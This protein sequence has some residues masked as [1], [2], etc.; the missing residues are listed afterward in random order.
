MRIRNKRKENIISYVFVLVFSSWIVVECLRME[1]VT[2][3]L[4]PLIFAG[5]IAVL[6]VIGLVKEMRVKEK[7]DILQD[8]VATTAETWRNYARTGA[9]MVGFLLSVYLFSLIVAIPL[10]TLCY[11]RW[12]GTKWLPSILFAVSVTVFVY[13]VFIIVLRVDMSEG[14]LLTLFRS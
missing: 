12:H 5:F 4:L 1:Y 9:W 3:K 11:T 6:A 13:I 8:K 10:F 7:P 14:L 2:S